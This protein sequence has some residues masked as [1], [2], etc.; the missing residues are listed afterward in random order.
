MLIDYLASLFE[1]HP[2]M[3]IVASLFIINLCI[4]GFEI[5]LDILTEK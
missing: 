4:T 1:T 2:I 5:I 3:L